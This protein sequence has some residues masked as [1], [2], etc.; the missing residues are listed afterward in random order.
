VDPAKDHIEKASLTIFDPNT[1]SEVTHIIPLEYLENH[2]GLFKVAAHEII[3][4]G[5]NVKK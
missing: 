5:R 3:K 1:S 2:E 4:K